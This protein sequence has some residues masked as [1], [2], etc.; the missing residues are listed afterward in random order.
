MTLVLEIEHLTGVAFAALG[1]DSDQPDWPPQ[2]DR[3]FSALVASWAARGQRAAEAEALR[4]LEA[5]PMPRIAA[6]GH[7]ARSPATRFV[8]PNDA[9]TGGS[10]NVA[11]VP[12]LRPRQPRRFSATRPF[13]PLVRIVWPGADPDDATMAA[14][15]TLAADTAYV[16][17]STSL[18]RCRFTRD[19]GPPPENAR[20]PTRMVYPGRLDELRRDFDAGRRP[21]R[22]VPVKPRADEG[23]EIAQGVF[24]GRW[25]FL[26]HVVLE[27]ETGA[28]TAE[29]PDL[30]SS[31]LVAKAIH[32][33]LLSGYDR[34]GRGKRIPEAVSGH[35][36]DNTPSRSPHIAIVPLSFTGFPHAD[37]R[38][39]GFAVIPP[40]DG[41]PLD[42]ADFLRA[43]RA[44]APADPESERHV[45]TLYDFNLALAPTFEPPPRLRSFDPAL[46]TM[47]GTLF[48]TVTPIV[49]DRHLK[50]RGAARQ[51]E[52]ARQIAAACRN[53]GLPEPKVTHIVPD[54]HSAV[55][56]A[57][58]AYPSGNA[59]AW[60]RWKLPG[61]LASRQLTHA[62]IRFPEPVRGPVLL[63][64]G[65]FVGLGLC[66]PLDPAMRQP[67][68]ERS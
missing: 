32:K 56:G 28:R 46:Y 38:A 14:L 12:A 17:H 55:E 23:R 66:R 63:G 7:A 37:G 1:P 40:R 33:A 49:L 52:I 45:V 48:A 19:A 68:E 60:M 8:P 64:A 59:P 65:R 39:L 22:G 53:A 54:K 62:V 31:P 15:E 51:D 27:T 25:L 58:S 34:I 57:P 29:M 67:A 61:S 26:E 2:P 16:G 20:R 35:R 42:D 41:N 6:S 21:N 5:Q 30:R 24:A 43:L 11:V 4:W 36:P 44:I 13:D 18:T 10:G 47:P 9:K 3:I 50:E